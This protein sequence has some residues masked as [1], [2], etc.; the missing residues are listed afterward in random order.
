MTRRRLLICGSLQ[1][2][3]TKC[4]ADG[5]FTEPVLLADLRELALGLVGALGATSEQRFLLAQR[6]VRAAGMD[7]AHIAPSS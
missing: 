2:P 3:R 1:A 6:I 7:E 4:D 5:N